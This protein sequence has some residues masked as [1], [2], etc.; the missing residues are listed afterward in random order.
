MTAQKPIEMVT[1]DDTFTLDNL[2]NEV[3]CPVTFDKLYPGRE[4]AFTLRIEL[5]SDI[6]RRKEYFAGRKPTQH[7]QRLERL[8]QLIVKPPVGFSDFP[9]SG[10]VSENVR[11]YFKS[12]EKAGMLLLGALTEYDKRVLPDQLFR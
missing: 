2:V 3:T 10:N 1:A 5:E 7:E 4:F 12:E 8:A 6:D 11:R 9:T